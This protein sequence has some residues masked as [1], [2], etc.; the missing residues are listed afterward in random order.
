ML[1]DDDV[2]RIM[3]SGEEVGIPLTEDTA[4][5]LWKAYEKREG[6]DNITLPVSF[7]ELMDIIA[8]VAQEIGVVCTCTTVK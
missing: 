8:N 3:E 1:C 2:E 5:A 4:R 7:N 6:R